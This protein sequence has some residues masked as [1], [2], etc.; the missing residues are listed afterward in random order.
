MALLSLEYH[1]ISQN[2][3]DNLHDNYATQ[4]QTLDLWHWSIFIIL[5]IND[6]KK[7]EYYVRYYLNKNVS[8]CVD[9]TDQE[10][11]VNE[12]LSVPIIWIYEAKAMKAKYDKLL[13][14]EVDLL[15]KSC[16]WNQAHSL[17]IDSYGPDCLIKG[18]F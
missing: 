17:I 1:H 11:F 12:N 4:L 7:R 14:N 15:M 2:C 3:I 8:S 16:K 9:L 5:H 13:E 6:E 18:N 10:K